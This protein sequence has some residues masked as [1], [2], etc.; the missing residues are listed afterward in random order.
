MSA[1]AAL[2]TS[3]HSIYVGANG[4]I[5]DSFPEFASSAMAAK[6]LLSRLCGGAFPMFVDRMCTSCLLS[7]SSSARE[8][9]S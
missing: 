8:R 9:E 5:V 7:R 2:V 4:Y 6:T 1:D 3:P